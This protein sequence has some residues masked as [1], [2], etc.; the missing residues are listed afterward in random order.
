MRT[1]PCSSISSIS[2]S[3][4]PSGATT[5]IMSRCALRTVRVRVS[6][7]RFLSDKKKSKKKTRR[8]I[9]Q[10]GGEEGGGRLLREKK[11]RKKVENAKR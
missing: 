3:T 11:K 6:E 4:P 9:K 10:K 5:R 1:F 7:R 8:A 2:C